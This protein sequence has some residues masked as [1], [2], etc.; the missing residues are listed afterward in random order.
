MVADERIERWAKNM[1]STCQKLALHRCDEI[2][3]VLPRKQAIEAAD[4]WPSSVVKGRNVQSRRISN[5][6]PPILFGY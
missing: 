6:R 5:L 3:T 2:G 1:A 4:D